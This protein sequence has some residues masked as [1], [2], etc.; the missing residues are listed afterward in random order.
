M[1]TNKI[2]KGLFFSATTVFL[3]GGCAASNPFGIGYDKTVCEN[4]NDLGFCGRPEDI[5]KYKRKI[6]QVQKDYIK[7]GISD[8]LY[9]AIT[10]D[11]T[12][13]VK[14]ER[15]GP[16]T[17]YLISKWYK[18]IHYRLNKETQ[19]MNNIEQKSVFSRSKKVKIARV[20]TLKQDIPVTRGN[21][22]S[23]QYKK[24][25]TILETR[26]NTG[27]L[28]RSYGQIQKV[29]IAP[30]V[31]KKQ[32]L[33]TAHEIFIVLKNPKWIVGEKYPNRVKNSDIGTIPTP[34]SEDIL[35]QQQIYNKYNEKV[36]DF[37][38]KGENKELKNI[39]N[40]N[41]YKKEK[42]QQNKMGIIY[43]FLYK[44]KQNKK[45]TK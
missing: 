41:P 22:L 18:I 13:L 40:N 45:E 16:W 23:V 3:L 24:Q 35:N 30:Y 15:E 2:L 1:E 6:K 34:I 12:V 36:V 8:K 31:D 5:Y 44:N 27:N 26:T 7:S 37:Y 32:N 11:G 14:N 19:I 9:F 29:W 17:P 43:K 39:I 42:Q 4:A 20:Y 25:S 33:V 10:D 21:D 28:I 38:N